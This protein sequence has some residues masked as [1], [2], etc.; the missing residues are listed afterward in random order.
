MIR[1]FEIPLDLALKLEA[2]AKRENKKPEELLA[3]IVS[4]YIEVQDFL[5]RKMIQKESMAKAPRSRLG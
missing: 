2:A 3:H 4:E 5:E 1:G